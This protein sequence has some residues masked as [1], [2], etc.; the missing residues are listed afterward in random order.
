MKLEELKNVE[1]SHN[2][3]VA[4][5]EMIDQAKNMEG[6]MPILDWAR[7]MISSGQWANDIADKLIDTDAGYMFWDGQYPGCK[8]ITWNLD[9]NMDDGHDIPCIKSY[10]PDYVMFKVTFKTE[11][12]EGFKV[13]TQLKEILLMIFIMMQS[14][15]TGCCNAFEYLNLTHDGI[16]GKA[17]VGR[18]Y[19]S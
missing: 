11:Y 6:A 15:C 2:D 9:T 18:T 4:L 8:A 5:G 7:K 13:D 10:E 3:I 16:L 12:S 17:Y 19:H 1:V 14:D